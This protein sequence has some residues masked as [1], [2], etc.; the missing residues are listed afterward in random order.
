MK[1]SGLRELLLRARPGWFLLCVV[2]GAASVL[3]F[4]PFYL[5][6]VP[7]LTLAALAWAWQQAPGAGQTAIL[8][9]GFGLG[10]F[11]TGT[12][13]VYVSM[14]D[15]GG[16]AWPVAAAATTV[17]CTILALFPAAA[18]W[19]FARTPASGWVAPVIIFPAAWALMEWVRGW[20]F[21]GFP[22]IALG[23]SQ[24]P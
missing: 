6:P 23:Y 7:V 18:G 2:L 13:W 10:Y 3:G 12:S 17:F 4:A 14:H 9:F 16:M 11:L 24:S 20:M 5:F 21:T 8:G 15:F 22:W 19:L 1:R